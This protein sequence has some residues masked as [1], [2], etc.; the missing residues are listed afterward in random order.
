MRSRSR[1]VPILEMKSPPRGVGL[2]GH[3]YT[4]FMLLLRL[5]KDSRQGSPVRLAQAPPDLGDSPVG[6]LFWVL[7]AFEITDHL[8]L[9]V[10]AIHRMVTQFSSSIMAG[11]AGTPG[12][13]NSLHRWACGQ[14]PNSR[15]VVGRLSR[16]KEAAQ[17]TGCCFG[18]GAS[19]ASWVVHVPL[20]AVLLLLGTTRRSAPLRGYW[21]AARRPRVPAGTN[22][23]W[24][25][26]P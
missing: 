12:P 10:R 26:A 9:F 20:S 17:V 14:T 5:F 18:V 7:V 11:G 16:C 21:S 4:Y 13:N 2:A 6:H 22:G 1:G 8:P 19:C 3:R 23:G 24:A 25:C 15:V